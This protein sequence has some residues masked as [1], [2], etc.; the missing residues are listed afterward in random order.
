MVLLLVGITATLRRGKYVMLVLGLVLTPYSYS[1]WAAVA[2]ARLHS[3]G[4]LAGGEV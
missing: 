3:D 1:I 2:L 4:A